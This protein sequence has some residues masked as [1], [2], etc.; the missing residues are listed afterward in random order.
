MLKEIVFQALKERKPSIEDAFDPHFQMSLLFLCTEKLAKHLERLKIY[1][2]GT[3]FNQL[4]SSMKFQML[5]ITKMYLDEPD[6]EM[7]TP[8]LDESV[9]FTF[10]QRLL[11]AM[12]LS[13]A[14]FG[15]IEIMYPSMYS[16]IRPFRKTVAVFNIMILILLKP[17]SLHFS[18]DTCSFGNSFESDSPEESCRFQCCRFRENCVAI[19]ETHFYTEPIRCKFVPQ[20]KQPEENM[21]WRKDGFVLQGDEWVKAVP[22]IDGKRFKLDDVNPIFINEFNEDGELINRFSGPGL[23]PDFPTFFKVERSN[24]WMLWI[25]VLLQNVSVPASFNIFRGFK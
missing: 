18:A 1:E 2:N 11:F 10:E 17:F 6:K 15:G 16:V 23:V 21:H 5:E 7:E 9:G 20:F 22:C 8:L 3:H 13:Q 19:D 4:V 14:I 24:N 25:F 12:L